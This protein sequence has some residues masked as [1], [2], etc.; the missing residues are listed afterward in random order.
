MPR[1]T[2]GEILAE[3]LIREKVPYVVGIP[4]HG[5]MGL[6]D[7]FK[8]REDRIRVL[9]VRHEQS[10]AHIAD[11]YYRVARQPLVVITSIGPGAV[12]TA[13]GVATA[14][15]DSM[16]MVVV[17][18]GAQTYMKGRGVLQ[19]LE[20]AHEDDFP[21]IMRPI[22]KESWSVEH[23]SHLPE[24]LHRAFKVATTGRPGP[25]HI[26]IPMDVQSEAADV[27]IPEPAEHRPFG[28]IMPDPE[29]VE[30]AVDVILASRRP[31]I[32][33]GGGIIGAGASDGLLRFA[34]AIGA[35]VVTTMMGKG[36]FPEDH[37][38]SAEHTGANGTLVG[39]HLS[40]NADLVI[41][42]GA[43]FAEQ[44]SSSFVPGA[45]FSIPPGKVVHVD[46]D[47][48]EIGKNY[49]TEVGIVA[50]ARSA[51]DA[52]DAA[53]AR[54]LAGPVPR[55]EYLA[56][57]AEWKAKWRR[58]IE[59]R[60]PDDRISTS[61]F[62]GSLRRFLDRDAITVVSAGHPQI[63]LFQEFP[64]YVPGASIT[65]GGYSS[66]GFTIPAAIGAKLAA[67][68]R[69]V[70]GIAGDGDFLM[71]IQE[72]AVAVENRIPVVYTVMNNS[73]W[74]S[75]RDF[76]RGMFGEDRPM[77]VDFVHHD[78]GDQ[79]TVDF[80]KI[81]EAFGCHSERITDPGEV[82]EAL[83]RAFASGRPALL[84]V[85][86]TRD[87]R[88]SGGMNHGHWDLPKPAYLGAGEPVAG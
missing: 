12:N 19:E 39:N 67:P 51:L 47:A 70:V 25:V 11:G 37:H 18:G 79:Y 6:F 87:P 7:A 52:L 74:V 71:T 83:G 31:I 57:I 9:Q 72:L 82:D 65:T 48:R 75:I 5:D 50:D 68:G 60:W 78:S 55:P 86:V 3:Y 84:E 22:T 63:Q 88:W 45:S 35:P 21:S 77:A 36:A 14:Y 81:G 24:V 53:L 80:Q 15:V 42:I 20:R 30:R 1:L 4:G 69:Q 44:T 27:E 8:E 56:E 40:R 16:A 85:M 26:Q 10:A 64:A 62:F 34:E 13:M 46:I 33:A 32:L 38:L 2:G 59:E 49:P 54:R 43:R 41:A 23:V 66:M 29:A 61:S 76:Q 73:G 28:R 58:A 17:T